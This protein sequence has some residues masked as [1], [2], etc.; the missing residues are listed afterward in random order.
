MTWIV[1]GRYRQFVSEVIDWIQADLTFLLQQNQKQGNVTP[2]MWPTA[3]E[4]HT[5]DQRDIHTLK[6]TD[7]L[8]VISAQC[9]DGLSAEQTNL[10]L[11]E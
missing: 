4:K 3:R 1:I 9:E 5:I 8:T 2:L 7:A 10:L 11:T 6:L